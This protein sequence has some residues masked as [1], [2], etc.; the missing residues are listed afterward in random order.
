MGAPD[1]EIVRGQVMNFFAVW[2]NLIQT[3]EFD[4]TSASCGPYRS[5]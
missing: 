2:L 3:S 5:A 4:A 1:T